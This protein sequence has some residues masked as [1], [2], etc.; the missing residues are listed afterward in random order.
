MPS[1]SG[2][3]QLV[4]LVGWPVGHSRSPAMHNAAAADLGLDLLYV[5]LSVRPD[6]LQS[7]LTGLAA[8]GFLGANVTVPHKEQVLPLLD[9]LDA[10]AEAIG[11]V[12]TIIVQRPSSD[13]FRLKGANTDW[14]GFMDDLVRLQVAVSGRRCLVLGAGGSARAVAYG[15]AGA[16]C[17]VDVAARRREQAEQLTAAL[18]PHVAGPLAAH[19]WS[20]L[21]AL[22]EAAEVA[23]V[24]NT[25][26]LGM[27]PAVEK[28]P[29]PGDLPFPPQAFVYDLVYNP[30][31]TRLLTQA[32]RA[33]RPAANGLGMLLGQGA[34]AFELWTGQRPNLAVMARA[35]GLD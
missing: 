24:V 26:P 5:P 12:N 35:L 7:A 30:A 23:L 15:L 33:G 1:V 9:E 17:H 11:A 3:T 19:H 14:R 10:A 28:S 29:W 20:A 6:E 27:E 18:S 34:A 32:R 21:A 13:S 22:A 25:T 31:E 16:G 8:L 4:G 2:T